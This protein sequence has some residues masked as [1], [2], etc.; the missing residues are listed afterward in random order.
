MRVLLDASLDVAVLNLFPLF[1]Y[2]I[3]RAGE[4]IHVGV[5]RLIDESSR[6]ESGRESPE[7]LLLARVAKGDRE[8]MA[9][10][11]AR[12]GRP[13]FSYLFHM[14]RQQD[15]A[16]DVL[17]EVMVI[18]WQKAH[19]FRGTAQ[20]AS[21]IFGIAHNQALKALRRHASVTF[22]ELEAAAD[23]QNEVSLPEADI[24][25][26]TTRQEIAKAMG[27]LTPE[28]REVLVL[29]FFYDFACKEIAAI[30]GIPLGTVKSRL[31]YARQALK[32]ALILNGW[33][34][35]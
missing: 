25:R 14:L 7:N 34:G 30:V 1:G 20:A 21:W 2:L 13:L 19:T 12:L 8:A 15:L 23:L 35:Q 3:E 17:Q 11:Y 6:R 9:Q 24:L 5:S 33:E 28:H 31:S 27:H 32:T 10:V 22:V 18:V 16:E 26:Q 4:L 29:A